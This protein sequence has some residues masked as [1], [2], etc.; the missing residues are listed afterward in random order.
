MF[1]EQ[2]ELRKQEVDKLRQI[3]IF[4]VV[5][6]L[7]AWFCSPSSIKAPHQDLMFLK[8]LIEYKNINAEISKA[9]STKFSNHL[10]YLSEELVSLSLFDDEVS[11]DVKLEILKSMEERKPIDQNLKRVK[12]EKTNLDSFISKN[13]ADFASQKSFTIFKQ[14]QLSTNFF[15]LHPDEWKFNKEYC[16]SLRVFQSLHVVNDTAERGVQLID[17]YNQSLTYNEEQKQYLL[18][19]VQMHRRQYPKANKNILSK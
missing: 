13:L 11:S 19:V 8:S 10:W 14:Y 5:I 3:C 18:Q 15:N 1:K 17:T 4:I 6:Y 16:D 9:A 7:K 12:V 2:F